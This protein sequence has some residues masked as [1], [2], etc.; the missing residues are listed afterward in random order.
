VYQEGVVSFQVAEGGPCGERLFV[1]YNA[2]CHDYAIQMP[3]GRWTI[4]ADG[5][6]A[7]QHRPLISHG[8]WVTVHP[9]SGMLLMRQG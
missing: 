3:S 2:T 9:R 1:A 6:N 5:A 4:R 8:N 7:D